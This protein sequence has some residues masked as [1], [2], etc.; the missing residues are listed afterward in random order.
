MPVRVY[1]ISKKLGLENK[2][3]LAK[4]KAMG[5]AAAKVPSSALDKITAEDLENHLLADHPELAAKFAAPPV[6]ESPK[7][8]PVEEKVVFITAPPPPPPPQVR[9]SEVA[10]K[11][12]LPIDQV[13][14]IVKE[15]SLP[16]GL[17]PDSLNEN[18]A[19]ELMRLVQSGNVV[20]KRLTDLEKGGRSL[21]LRGFPL[22]EEWISR[23]SRC[24]HIQELNL[25]NT[26]L[27]ILPDAF[28]ELT[29]LSLLDLSGNNLEQ[30]PKW[31]ANF[32]QIKA[33][34][35]H[36]NTALNLPT[37]ILG[38]ASR[39]A[40]PAKPRDIL[41][42]YSR[43]QSGGK[44]PLNEAKLILLG[45]G[46][47]G[48]TCLVNRMVHNQFMDTTMTCGI[49]ITQWK[50]KVGKDTIR[51][52]VWDFGGQEIQHATHQFFLTERSLYLV[53]LNGRAGAEDDDAEYWLK[54]VKTFGGGSPTIV[55]LNKFKVQ[56]FEVDEAGLKEKYPF[57]REFIETDCEADIGIA[58]L[59]K[60]IE[61]ALAAMDHIRVD[62]PAEWF[63]IKEKLSEM[64][65]PF[66]SFRQY[67]DLCE[68][69]TKRIPRHRR[70]LLCS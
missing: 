57:V 51:L 26:G 20:E 68:N 14:A 34:Y 12:G 19:Q 28:A 65:E 49:S 60:S 37:E 3:I 31:L 38:P 11:V 66:I 24:K 59:C 45:R 22:K 46:E 41:D 48:K 2:E 58:E 44:R 36:G 50:V 27:S 6:V 62:F 69:R 5:I 29:E 25:S 1:D 17:A 13:Q 61:T 63:Q 23:I 33:L 42:Y 64:K 67:R 43:L 52:H 15:F 16:F 35:L 7:P 55:I 70:S 21:G 32:P 47:V 39:D 40:E 53:V 8:P 56:P 30:L 54:F 18:T 10:R 9:I 4:A